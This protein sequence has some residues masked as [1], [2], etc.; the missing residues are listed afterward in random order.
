M[1]DLVIRN[2]RV[3]DGGGGAAFMGDVAVKDGLIS[4]IGAVAGAGKREIDAYT[5]ARAGVFV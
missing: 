3:V 1:D 5:E 4:A 2:A